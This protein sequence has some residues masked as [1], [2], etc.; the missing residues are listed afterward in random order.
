MTSYSSS[1]LYASYLKKEK[2]NL[3]L[4]RII[5]LLYLSGDFFFQEPN[6]R[7]VSLRNFKNPVKVQSLF[8]IKILQK[9]LR[10]KMK[11]G[12]NTRG[13]QFFF[14]KRHHR[15]HHHNHH[16]HPRRLLLRH[17]LFRGACIWRF[18]L[19]KKLQISFDLGEMKM[20]SWCFPWSINKPKHLQATCPLRCKK[21]ILVFLV[22][23]PLHLIFFPV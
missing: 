21:S 6:S 1:L 20:I 5:F 9:L 11:Q 18:C 23:F 16:H 22:S 12:W 10:F 17:H 14:I 3:C 2:K 13:T 4:K 15:L 19:P 7:S 8:F